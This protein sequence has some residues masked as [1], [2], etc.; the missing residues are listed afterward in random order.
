MNAQ[1]PLFTRTVRARWSSK[2]LTEECMNKCALGCAFSKFLAQQNVFLLK[3]RWTTHLF[4]G[5]FLK[6]WKVLTAPGSA[7]FPTGIVQNQLW[8]PEK[9]VRNLFNL[10]IKAIGHW[11]RPNVLTVDFEQISYTVLVFSLFIC[12]FILPVKQ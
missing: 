11:H 3:L 1:N 9:N 10:M 8:K 6:F 5:H 2:N 12:L 4:L 7:Y